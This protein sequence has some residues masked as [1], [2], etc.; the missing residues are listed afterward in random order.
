MSR[1]PDEIISSLN[2]AYSALYR[3]IEELPTLANS[4]AE[5]ER[6]YEVAM[7]QEILKLK[8]E[9]QSIT[10]ILK[11]ASGAKHVADL[12]FQH[13][14]ATELYKIQKIKIKTYETGV[15]KIQSELGFVKVEYQKASLQEGQEMK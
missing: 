7:R 3:S 14:L 4:E 6:N 15:N 9:G 8:S 11:L 13:H 12:K 5:A 2:K 1:T 10:L